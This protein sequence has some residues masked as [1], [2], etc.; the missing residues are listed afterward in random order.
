MVKNLKISEKH[1]TLLKDH[2]KKN[3]LKMFAYIERLIEENCTEETD[4]YDE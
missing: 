1:H 4:L 3:G 2:C